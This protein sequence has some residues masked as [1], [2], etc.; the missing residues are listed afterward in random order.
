MSREQ[1]LQHYM[2]VFD[3]GE[4][5]ACG[6]EATKRLIGAADSL[7]PGVSHGNLDT[8]SMDVAAIK[9]LARKMGI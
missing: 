6:R 5:R 1:F 9:A 3:N 8:G 4:I 7:E 2:A